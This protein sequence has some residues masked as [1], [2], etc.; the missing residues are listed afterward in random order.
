VGK[1]SQDNTE[2]VPGSTRDRHHFVHIY[3]LDVAILLH[4]EDENGFL[5][6]CVTSVSLF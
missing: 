2:V 3:T 4:F 6:L 1:I 5:T